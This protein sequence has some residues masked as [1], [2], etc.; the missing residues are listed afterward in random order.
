MSRGLD[1]PP[2]RMN[3][4]HAIPEEFG[5]F[6][7]RFDGG[8]YWLAHEELERLWLRE[9]DEFSKGLIHL[10][11]GLLHARRGNWRGAHAK[12]SSARALIDI[13]SPKVPGVRLEELRDALEE[14]CNVA[15]ARLAGDGEGSSLVAD[16]KLAPFF[17]AGAAADVE[18]VE[19]PYRVRRH[20]AGYRPGRDPRRRD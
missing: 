4:R 3:S 16:L 12:I 17:P 1:S 10:A 2:F 18:P 19:L 8:E 14:L 9:R 20:A 11:A 15:S 6:V 5:R 13:A 7:A